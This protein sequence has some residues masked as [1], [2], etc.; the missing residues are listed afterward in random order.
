M[1]QIVVQNRGNTAI[2]LVVGVVIVIIIIIIIRITHVWHVVAI[3]IVVDANWVV[4]EVGVGGWVHVVHAVGGAVAVKADG[5]GVGVVV[6]LVLGLRLRKLIWDHWV[7]VGV[8]S[9]HGGILQ[10][11]FP[12]GVGEC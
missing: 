1:I 7:G 12:R 9:K 4:D 5:L 11:E 10:C 6:M 3:V 8:E 2:W